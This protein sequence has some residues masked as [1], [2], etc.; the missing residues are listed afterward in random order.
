VRASPKRYVRPTSAPRATRQK[1]AGM[2]SIE[3][4]D[5]QSHPLGM[6]AERIYAIPPLGMISAGQDPH[7]TDATALFLDRTAGVAPPYALT[8]LNGPTLTDI[9]RTLHGLPLAI[10]TAASWIRVLSPSDLLASLTKA[11]AALG[12]DWAVVEERHRI[13]KWC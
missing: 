7:L 3:R 4:A 9:C 2:S 8:G 1:C 6:A 12:S 13:I 10:E 11:H 5:H